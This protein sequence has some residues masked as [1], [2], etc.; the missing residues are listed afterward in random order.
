[1]LDKETRKKGLH[2]DDLQCDEDI[3][4]G[5]ID[6]ELDRCVKFVFEVYATDKKNPGIMSKKVGEQFF[7][8]CLELYAMRQQKKPKEIIP[9]GVDQKK[10]AASCFNR[11]ANGKQQVTFEEFRHF[12][13]CYDIEEALSDYL[14]HPPPSDVTISTNIQFVDV[15]QFA[16][17][18]RE[19]PKLVY[20]EYPD[21]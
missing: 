17:A 6:F 16:N 20:R 5:D 9:K 3:I 15:S 10:A 14:S 1:M 12:L 2:L 11:M 7:K 4:D 19:G 8:D 13:N 21:D 18:Q